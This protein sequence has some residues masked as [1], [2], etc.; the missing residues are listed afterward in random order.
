MVAPAAL[1]RTRRAKTRPPAVHA[2]DALGNPVRRQM[3]VVL[4][5]QPLSVGQL[6]RRFPV[7]RPAV[8]RHLRVLMDAGLVSARRQGREQLY[9][10][11]LQGFAS[12]REF[13]DGFWDTALERLEALARA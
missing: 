5:R 6:A 9:A 3:L 11:R 10:I 13:M 2:L 8:S 1:P 12:V 4:R 7:T